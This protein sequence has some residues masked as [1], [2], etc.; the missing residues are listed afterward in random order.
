[1]QKNLWINFN[2]RICAAKDA[3]FPLNR[4]IC[5]GDGLF[6]SIRIHNGEILFFNDH[7]DRMMRGMNALRLEVPAQYDAFFFHKQIVELALKEQ[8]GSNARVRISIF[9]DGMGLY[10]P[11]SDA[12]EYFMHIT[13]LSA[14]Y[15]W[16]DDA[17]QL[18]TF[19]DVPK[20]F[21]S[22]SGFKTLNALPYILAAIYRREQH[23]DDCLLVNSFG[24]I[25]D[26]I[27]SNIFWIE[28]KTV[29]TTP[30][31]DGGVDGILRKQMLQLLEKQQ[32]TCIEK[33]ITPEALSAVDEIFLTNVGHGIRPVTKYSGRIFSTRK[34]KEI[35][36]LLYG[37][38]LK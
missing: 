15:V 29:Y 7:L 30:V 18:G 8:T 5:Y 21:S 24:N 13:S 22:V 20:D 6:E 31:S 36:E 28:N 32:V 4:A 33:S 16:K 34:T 10:E 23:L 37:F 26:G 3:V 35:A 17:C 25:A 1:M 2:G 9:R 12:P 11:E 19:R 27:S 14:G 38:L